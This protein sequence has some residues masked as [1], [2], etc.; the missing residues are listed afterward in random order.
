MLAWGNLFIASDI[1]FILRHEI[2]S[3]KEDPFRIFLTAGHP[4]TVA[5]GVILCQ[6]YNA[7][8]KF[9]LYRFYVQARRFMMVKNDFAYDYTLKFFLIEMISNALIYI[10]FGIFHVFSTCCENGS[11]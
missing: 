1:F 5:N 2:N 11:T 8:K 10:F 6:K 7:I 9:G 4:L 3:A